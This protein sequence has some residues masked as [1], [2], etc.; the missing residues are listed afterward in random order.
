MGENIARPIMMKC[1]DKM[2]KYHTVKGFATI[3][4]GKAQSLCEKGSGTV[5]ETARRVLRTTVPDP[6]AH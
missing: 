5:A 1:S 6:F 4:L 2:R 3:F